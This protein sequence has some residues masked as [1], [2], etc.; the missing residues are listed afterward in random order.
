MTTPKQ[1]TFAV[2]DRVTII[3][4]HKNYVPVIVAIADGKATVKTQ[5]VPGSERVFKISELEKIK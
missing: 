2:G 4:F 1:P 5:G 3:G